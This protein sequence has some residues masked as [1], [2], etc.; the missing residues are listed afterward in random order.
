MDQRQRKGGK[1]GVYRRRKKEWVRSKENEPFLCLLYT[2]E[3]ID[4]DILPLYMVAPTECLIQESAQ[5][6]QVNNQP[7]YRS[8][9]HRDMQI[10]ERQK[11]REKKRE[12]GRERERERERERKREI[13]RE[14]KREKKK[15]E[16]EN[17]DKVI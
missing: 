10:L 7:G 9:I 17:S 6:Q 12:R 16:R 13:K 1:K 4:K 2:Y 3:W 8:C 15:R 5:F 14:K 11:E